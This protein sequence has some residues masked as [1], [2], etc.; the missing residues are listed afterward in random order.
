MGKTSKSLIKIG[1]VIL[2][3]SMIYTMLFNFQLPPQGG[4]RRWWLFML[5][6]IISYMP[7]TVGLIIDFIKR[8]RTQYKHKPILIALTIYLSIMMVLV[9]VEL[10]RAYL[11]YGIA[12]MFTIPKIFTR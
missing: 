5:M 7:I 2:A 9:S 4:F 8:R 3:V 10:M 11:Q 1:F 12:V 6:T